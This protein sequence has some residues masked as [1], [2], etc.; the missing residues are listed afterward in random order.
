MFLL[1]LGIIAESSFQKEE[2]FRSEWKQ[3]LDQVEVLHICFCSDFIS[4]GFWI[5]TRD[6]LSLTTVLVHH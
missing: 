2:S 4:C 3:T 6:K 5:T 1:V